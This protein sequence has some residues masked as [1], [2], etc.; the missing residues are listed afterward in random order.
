LFSVW[1]VPFKFS[2]LSLVEQLRC[3]FFCNEVFSGE[4]EKCCGATIAGRLQQ[5]E[6]RHN[7]RWNEKGFFVSSAGDSRLDGLEVK[8]DAIGL[9]KSKPVIV[10]AKRRC[11]GHAFAERRM[12]SFQGQRSWRPEKTRQ[13]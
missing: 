4:Y 5:L 12:R 6:D 13:T 11:S 9:L 1:I 8:F 3:Q 2:L 7:Q 10:A